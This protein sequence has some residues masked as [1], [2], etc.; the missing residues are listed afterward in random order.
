MK[1]MK[2]V[3]PSDAIFGAFSLVSDIQTA[4]DFY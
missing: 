1:K 2:T 4:R 3:P